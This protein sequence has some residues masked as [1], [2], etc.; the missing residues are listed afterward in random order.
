VRLCNNGLRRLTAGLSMQVRPKGKVAARGGGRWG[1]VMA[2]STGTRV[3]GDRC[4]VSR[5][6]RREAKIGLAMSRAEGRGLS[7][8]CRAGAADE[9]A[10]LCV[11]SALSGVRQATLQAD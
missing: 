7:E 8:L 10:V 5:H 6:D 1:D 4:R 3:R 2:G 11:L 9:G